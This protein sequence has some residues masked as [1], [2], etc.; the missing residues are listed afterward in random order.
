MSNLQLALI[1]KYNT[2]I[3]TMAFSPRP[4]LSRAARPL[5]RSTPFAELVRTG[6]TARWNGTSDTSPPKLGLCFCT[7]CACGPSSSLLNFGLLPFLR[8]DK[9]TT[10]HLVAVKQKFHTSCSPTK[11]QAFT[12]LTS[13]FS[14]APFLFLSKNFKMAKPF[15][16][17]P[18]HAATWESTLDNLNTM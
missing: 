14:G 11:L 7:Q 10:T 18:V 6:R 8:Q 2:S 5:S 15:Q 3:P 16:N 9:F 17:V 1:A 13:E 12:H 4:L